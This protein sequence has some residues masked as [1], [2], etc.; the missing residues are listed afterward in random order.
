[1]MCQDL[2]DLKPVLLTAARGDLVSENRFFAE[3][4]HERCKHKLRL[5]GIGHRPSGETTRDGDHISLRVAAIYAKCVEFHDFATV[6]LVQAV[7]DSIQ[8][9]GKNGIRYAIEHAAARRKRPDL[10]SCRR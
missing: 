9:P 6:V 1:M 3:I 7:G 2:D 4:V 8:R 5:F 10:K